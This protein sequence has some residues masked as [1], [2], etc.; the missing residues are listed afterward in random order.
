MKKMILKEEKAVLESFDNGEFKPVKNRD[1]E[2][3]KLRQY[4]RN[5]LQKNKR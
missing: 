5:T 4:A 3:A 2:M 1:A